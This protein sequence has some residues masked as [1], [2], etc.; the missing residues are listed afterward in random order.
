VLTENSA[1]FILEQ[2]LTSIKSYQLKHLNKA[3]LSSTFFSLPR[4]SNIPSFLPPPQN[5]AKPA[6]EKLFASHMAKLKVNVHSFIRF[7]S[8]G[9]LRTLKQQL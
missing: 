9:A 1:K 4:D 8:S 3:S 5:S 2:S 6:E 7:A